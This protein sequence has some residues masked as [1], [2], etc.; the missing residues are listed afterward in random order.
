[1]QFDQ[2]KSMSALFPHDAVVQRYLH[3]S[4]RRSK[5]KIVVASVIGVLACGVV[6]A[7]LP[8]N[9]K[10]GADKSVTAEQANPVPVAQPVAQDVANR[11]EA[12]PM[13]P[14]VKIEAS[15]GTTGAAVNQSNAMPPRANAE[16]A[17]NP[18]APPPVPAPSPVV[19]AAA[20][21]Q[22]VA[23]IPTVQPQVTAPVASA[24]EGHAAGVAAQK[25]AAAKLARKHRLAAAERRHRAA[26]LRPQ[27]ASQPGYVRMYELPDGRRVYQ[28]VTG[29]R[30]GFGY[31]GDGPSFFA[32]VDPNVD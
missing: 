15:A 2:E 8:V 1:V 23:E 4:P 30:P 14:K 3:T 12:P 31:A 11:T 5:R 9:P 21:P 19:Q 20:A 29:Y 26:R 22:A 16:T 6:A 28:R 17:A 32:P 10:S 25:R 27:P 24:A 13:P 18:P 7:A